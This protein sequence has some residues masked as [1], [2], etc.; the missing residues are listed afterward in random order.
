MGKVGKAKTSQKKR[1][2]RSQKAQKQDKQIAT[3]NSKRILYPAVIQEYFSNPT[4]DLKR[5]MDNGQTLGKNLL[6]GPGKVV[7]EML[8]TRMPRN[9]VAATVVSD[10]EGQAISGGSDKPSPEIFYPL[11]P[12]LT[13]PAKPGEQVWVIYD[14]MSR[15][16]S[17]HGYWFSRVAADIKVDDPNYT[18]KEREGIINGSAG[19]SENSSP[20]AA[21]EAGSGGSET[22]AP[23]EDALYGFSG[24]GMTQDACLLPSN[25]SY[26]TIVK[27]SASYTDQFQG[28][29]VPRFHPRVGDL[30][31]EG[32]NNTLVCLGQ[33]RVSGQGP[34]A[35]KE[36]ADIPENSGAIDIVSGR[37]QDGGDGVT[38][39]AGSKNLTD[40]LGSDSSR[41]YSEN[42]KLAAANPTEGD[43]DFATDLSR[44]YVA[45]NASIDADFRVSTPSIGSTN[46]GD[47]GTGPY[48]VIKS[49]NP[50]VIARSDGS[51]KIVHESG[52]SINMDSGG[53]VSIVTAGKISM[54]TSANDLEP[55]VRGTSLESALHA[56]ADALNS[57]VVLTPAGPSSPL[58]S[59]TTPSGTFTTDVTDFKQAVTDSLSEIIEGE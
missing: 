22:N 10:G 28:E 57:L 33:H 20:L 24:G 48:V 6:K 27:E 15:G 11:F 50:R 53:N 59:G 49:T 35:A 45:S 58:S 51:V 8:L 44:V 7:N 36:S 31:L 16:K 9:S 52:A 34:S 40:I 3:A 17:A 41:N 21:F 2:G 55:F 25:T 54:G 13:L 29:V 4:Q 47:S 30:C 5:V 32:S 56:F 19:S 23:P 1:Y 37:G 26:D 42:D 43:P 14:T 12:H 38:A 18:H 39:V 46:A